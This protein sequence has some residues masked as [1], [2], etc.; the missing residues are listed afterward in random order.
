MHNMATTSPRL[1]T[2]FASKNPLMVL[3]K[4][5]P[6]LGILIYLIS[7]STTKWNFLY[8]I[9]GI[10]AWSVFEYTS[11]RWVYHKNFKNR[12]VRWLLETFHLYHHNTPKDYRVLNAGFFLMYPLAIV[13]WSLFYLFTLDIFSATWISLGFLTYYFFYENIHYFIHYKEFK[14][15]YLRKMQL[16]HLHHHHRNWNKNYG[17]TT[18]FWDKIL[19]TYDKG[20]KTFILSKEQKS[21][22]IKSK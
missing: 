8:F 12:R 10:V 18:L 1:L 22:F 4:L 21:H 19:G 17:N 14:N 7:N 5:A 16:Y 6:I 3:V 9:I 2:F 11:H 13:I 20:F 15:G